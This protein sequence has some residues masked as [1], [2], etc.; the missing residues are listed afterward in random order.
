MGGYISKEGNF[1]TKSGHIPLSEQDPELFDMIEEEKNRQW[2][3]LEMIASENFTSQAVLECLGSCLT[4]KYSE[5]YPNHRYYGGNGVI[6]K[7]ELLCQKRALEAFH[8]D[9]EQWG[10]NVQPYSGSP[11]NL[12]VYLGLLHP[13]S[14]VM[15]LDL[16]SGGHLTHGYSTFS[17]KNG[18]KNLS[19]TSIYYE[20]MPYHICEDTGLID[21]NEL[22]LLATNFKPQLIIAGASAYPREYDYARFRAIADS[23]GAYLMMDMAHISGLVATQEAANPFEYCDIVTTTTHKSLRGPR[24]GMIF[25]KKDERD[26]E[27]KINDAVFPGL[28]GG[29]HEHQIAGIACQLKEVMTSEYKEYCIQ[30]KKNAKAL[31]DALLNKGYTICTHGTDNHLILWDLRPTGLSGNKMEKICELINISLNKNTVHGDKSA[32]NPGGV[33]I[34]SP[35][36]TSRGFKEEDFV[37]IA[38]FLDKAVHIALD[39]QTE[40]GKLLKDWLLGVPNNKDIQKVAHEVAEFAS[41]FPIPGI[42]VSS[43]KYQSI[44]GKQEE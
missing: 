36:L 6:D 32:Y 10:V 3:S 26:F 41:S 25:F 4:N 34:G 16:P 12:A 18:R 14:R 35:A 5:G 44:D 7:I 38:D 21:Y 40:K 29:P 15:G 13:G 39:I 11:A 33:R 17:I 42:D 22:E 8:L 23:I 43:M 27:K 24:A 19:S 37:K 31:A 1:T 9:P 30:I 28:Q 2:R 20:T